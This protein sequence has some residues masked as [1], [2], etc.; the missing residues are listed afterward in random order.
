MQSINEG[1]Y[2]GIDISSWQ[3][4][5]NFEDVKKDG[6]NIVYIKA[7]ESNNY[8]NPYLKS[9]YSGSKDNN[10]LV[11][12]YHF[13]RANIGAK[14]QAKY[15]VQ[16]IKGMKPDCKLALDIEVTE[17]I[18]AAELTSMCIEFLEEVKRLSGVGVVVYTYTYF[19]KD[20]LTTSLSSYPLW[21][22][23]YGV[24]TP[25]N[26]PIWNSWVGFQYSSTGSVSG[27]SG[28]CD[29][30]VFT[31]GILVNSD[32]VINIPSQNQDSSNT[33]NSNVGTKIYTVK[34]GDTL[35][36]IAQIYGTTW[37]HLATINNIS[38]PNLIY[39]GEKLIISGS[40]GSS[41]IAS[42]TVVA[43]DTLS[44]IAQ[45]FGTTWEALATLNNISNPNLIYPGE[46]LK[47][48]SSNAITKTYIVRQGDTLS[49]IAQRFG[50]TWQ[51][52]ASLNNISNPNL[53]Y[54]GEIIKLS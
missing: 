48:G 24:E 27:V 29:L 31:D 19:A 52:L 18:G 5:V 30:D 13:F 6:I 16:S 9:Y 14:E 23:N 50:T 12:F 17:G 53:I 21:I 1:K 36:G 10:L 32:V 28:N 20:N 44:G 2:R 47:I 25:L 40:S 42:Y 4:N 51:K 49:E 34:S 43:G 33:E 45:R 15:F 26:N 38:N 54:P 39:P 7:T 8:I 37:Q 3:G 41:T 22:A 46:V 11:G 35:S